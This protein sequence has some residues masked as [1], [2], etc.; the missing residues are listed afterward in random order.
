MTN[1]GKKKQFVLSDDDA[2]RLAGTCTTFSACYCKNQQIHMC[3]PDLLE[4]IGP[5][6]E[7]YEHMRLAII[8]EYEELE[9]SLD[10]AARLGERFEGMVEKIRTHWLVDDIIELFVWL[11]A[12]R[13]DELRV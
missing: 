10:L 5:L 4:Y 7:A 12:R 1:E 11:W 2:R 9:N 13:A 8:C 6:S 3:L